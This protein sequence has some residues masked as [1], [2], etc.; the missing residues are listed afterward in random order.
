M[1]KPT[2][3]AGKELAVQAAISATLS[4]LESASRA[5]V[6]AWL[7]ERKPEDFDEQKESE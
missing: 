3:A 5:R 4:K 1:A 6:L 7:G 2:T